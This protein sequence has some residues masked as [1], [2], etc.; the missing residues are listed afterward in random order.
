MQILVLN[1]VTGDT[2]ASV[3]VKMERT[4]TVEANY[5]AHTNLK[6]CLGKLI[7]KLDRKDNRTKVRWTDAGREE[8]TRLALK[9]DS[10]GRLDTRTQLIH[11]ETT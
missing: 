4:R 3:Q 1:Q 2:H 9:E 8:I 7:Y 6:V 11:E 5:N 10:C